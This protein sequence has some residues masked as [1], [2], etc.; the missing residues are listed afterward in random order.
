MNY[1]YKT[2]NDQFAYFI[3]CN[4]TV[5][6]VEISKI[7]IFRATY[8]FH[9]ISAFS[10]LMLTSVEI[11]TPIHTQYDEGDDTHL[12]DVPNIQYLVFGL[13]YEGNV[14]LYTYNIKN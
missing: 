5:Y 11:S 2:R 4:N 8:R 13:V 6:T 9:L 14:V 10:V 1:Q 3:S 7:Q 12:L